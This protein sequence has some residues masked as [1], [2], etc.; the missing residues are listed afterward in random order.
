MK[1]VRLESFTTPEVA[2][3]RLT[4]DSGHSG[5]GQMS[6]YHADIT[7]MVFHRQVAPVGSGSAD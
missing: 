4:T 1:I 2:F 5:I 3:V 7:T 6:T